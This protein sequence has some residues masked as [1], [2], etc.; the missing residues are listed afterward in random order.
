MIVDPYRVAGL[1]PQALTALEMGIL[2]PRFP[3]FYEKAYLPLRQKFHDIRVSG[4]M[5]TLLSGILGSGEMPIFS[6]IEIETINRCNGTCSFC[7]ANRR[8][9]KR[10]LKLMEMDL[11]D[12]IVRQLGELDYR[13]SIGIYLNNE[14]LLDSRVNEFCEIARKRAPKAYLHMFTNGTLLTVERTKGLMKNL[15]HMIVDTYND[16]QMLTGGLVEVARAV[17]ADPYLRSRVFFYLRR[18]NLIR[19]SRGGTAPNRHLTIP[20]SSRC[21]KPFLQMVVRPDGKLSL[22]CCDAYGFMTM[23]DLNKQGMVEAWRG[24]KYNDVRRRMLSDRNSIPMCRAC[25]V[26]DNMPMGSIPNAMTKPNPIAVI[27]I[28]G[29]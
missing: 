10:P 24:E 5:N 22:C 14:P 29:A 16:R 4:N 3:V 19:S 27:S 7:P 15:D 6:S 13:G 9:D 28:A 23:G 25:D 18:E 21:C 1:V 11:F 20:L 12:S 17:E 8:I 26:I 2:G